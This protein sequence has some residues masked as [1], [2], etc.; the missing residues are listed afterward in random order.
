MEFGFGFGGE[1]MGQKFFA[2]F[3]VK[4][5]MGAGIGSGKPLLGPASHLRG[6]LA[7]GVFLVVALD[8]LGWGLRGGAARHNTAAASGGRQGVEEGFRL[9]VVRTTIESRVQFAGRAGAIASLGKSDCQIEVIVGVAGIVLNRSLEIFDGFFLAAAGGDH[10]KVV[11]DLG[12][13]QARGDELKGVFGFREVSMSVGGEA[14]IEIC[15]AGDC[16]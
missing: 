15:L 11:I 16:A 6:H 13:R 14:E 7:E 5:R 4:A 3:E 9:G 12:Q 10:S 1:S 8:A 2:E